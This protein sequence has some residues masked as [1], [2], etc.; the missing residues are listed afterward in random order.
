MA[1]VDAPLLS[2]GA[3]GSI[4]KAA[5]FSKWRGRAYSRRYVVPS[6]PQS[7]EQTKT[8]GAFRWLSQVWKF[9]PALALAPWDAFAAGQPL[10]GRNAFIGKNTSVLRA[11]VNAALLIGSPGAKGGIPPADLVVAAGN[12]LLTATLTAPTLPTGWSIQA[13]IAWAVPN[14]NPQDDPPLLWASVAVED[15]T[16]AYVISITGLASAQEYIVNA[17]FRYTKADG[18]TAYGPSLSDLQTTT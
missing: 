15:L 12:D 2:F 14:A 10:T 16:A 3:S 1:K 6:N 9:A 5:V 13:G 17:W 18:T 4:A 8:R 7:T 11:E